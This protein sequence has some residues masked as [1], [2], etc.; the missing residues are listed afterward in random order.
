MLEIVSVICGAAVMVLEMAGARVIAPYLGTSIV[1]WTSLIGVIL[2]AMSIGYWLGGR[3]ADRNPSA[4]KLSAIILAGAL[5]VL[6]ASLA[7]GRI[8][9]ALANADLP[10]HVSAILAATLLFAFPALFMGMVS[11]YIIQVRLLDYQDKR[12]G[13]NAGSVMGR[14]FALS[15]IGAIAGTFLGGYWLVSWLGTRM[16]L[17]TVAAGLALAAI[18]AYSRSR[19]HRAAAA[20]VFCLSLAFGAYAAM[21]AEASPANGIDI[22]TRYNHLRIQEGTLNG[23]PMRFLI[24]DPGSVQSGMLVAEPN[25]LA[26]DYTRHYALAWHI[27]P[28]AKTFLMLGGGGYSVPKYL[29][30]H[31]PQSTIDVVEIDPGITDAA[32]KYF[33]LPDNERLRVFHEDARAFLNRKAAPASRG[34]SRPD[35]LAQY[36]VILGD[37]FSSSYNIPFHLGTEEC[38]EVIKALLRD[39]GVFACNIISAVNGEQG[40]VLRAIHAAFAAVFPQTHLFRVNPQT[41]PNAAQNVILIA[42]KTPRPLPLAWEEPMRSLL[43]GEYKTPLAND[44]PALTDDFAPVERYAMPMLRARR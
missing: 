16:I 33:A 17:Y 26:L 27:Q 31:K 42:L 14:F 36:D 41:S 9:R 1:V 6:L 7:N 15:T 32:K 38:A 19:A 28:K 35:A 8:L 29:L 11:P 22:D 23:A 40:Q 13:K 20:L 43:A 21:N 24:T 3:Y 4:K 2:A 12:A 34:D 37:T 10:L 44:T 39:D 25:T 5:F 18:L 30:S